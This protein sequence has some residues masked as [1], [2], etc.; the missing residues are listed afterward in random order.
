M[1]TVQS[2]CCSNTHT[3]RTFVDEESDIYNRPLLLRIV[4]Q[5]TRLEVSKVKY[6]LYME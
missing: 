2:L 3:Q 5:I 6:A 4:C 1:V